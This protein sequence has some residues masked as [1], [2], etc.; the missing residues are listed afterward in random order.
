[1]VCNKC[2]NFYDDNLLEC[3][4]CGA[5]QF[6]QQQGAAYTQRPDLNAQ[7]KEKLDAQPDPEDKPNT[8]INIVSLLLLPLLGIIIFFVEK[9]KHPIK[10][11]SA[12]KFGIGG[13]VL[14]FIGAIVGSVVG[15]AIGFLPLLL[16]EFM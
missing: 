6:G 2:G 15:V 12:L 9:D 14:S 4:H 5:V 8:A 13:Y 1:M 3:P 16:E 11:K 7:Y 10:A